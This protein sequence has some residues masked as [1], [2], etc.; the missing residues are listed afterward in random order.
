MCSI[1]LAEA[2]PRDRA[3]GVSG[4]K[5]AHTATFRP[6]SLVRL[7]N[8]NV[9]PSS[10]LVQVPL[11]STCD[12]DG[13]VQRIA[14]GDVSGR[15]VSLPIRE[16]MRV[17]SFGGVP[18]NRG[19]K[20]WP[21][22]GYRTRQEHGPAGGSPDSQHAGRGDRCYAPYVLSA[23]APADGGGRIGPA[24]AFRE[25]RRYCTW[26]LVPAMLPGRPAA[27]TGYAYTW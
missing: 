26:K 2:V 4:R 23:P 16:T 15:L 5:L 20:A 12:S 27:L 18:V 1:Q 7:M 19:R 6:L 8:R 11:R 25:W 21:L 10:R 17:A 13:L 9:A 24:P 22:G 14:P 3:V